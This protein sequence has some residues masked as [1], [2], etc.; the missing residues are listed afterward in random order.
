VYAGIDP[1]SG[2]RPSIIRNVHYIISSPQPNIRAQARL[3]VSLDR[4]QLRWCA[5]GYSGYRSVIVIE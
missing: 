5:A 3:G 2:K 1:L 4:R